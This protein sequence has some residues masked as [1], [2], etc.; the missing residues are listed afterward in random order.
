MTTYVEYVFL[1]NLIIDAMLIVLARKVLKLEIKK[2]YVFLSAL[3]GSVVAVV[4][5]LLKLSLAWS[6]TLK[7]PIGL[8]IVLLSG[9]FKTFKEFIYCFYTLYHCK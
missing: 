5:P 1:D 9:K 8:I 3:F 7:M 2:L 6:F 4:T